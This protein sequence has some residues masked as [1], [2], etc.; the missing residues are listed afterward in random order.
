MQELDK[1]GLNQRSFA[2]KCKVSHRKLNYQLNGRTKV[3]VD[4]VIMYCK[5]LDIKDK[6][7]ICQIFLPEVS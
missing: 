1:R 3:T 2:K 7:L 4:D 5:I 6:L